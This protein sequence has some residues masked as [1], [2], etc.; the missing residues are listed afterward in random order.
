M[1]EF[2]LRGGVCARVRSPRTGQVGDDFLPVFDVSLP[3]SEEMPVWPGDPPVRVARL[4]EPGAIPAVSHLSF[5]SHTGTHVDA[6]AHFL[7]EGATIDRLP[8]DLWLGPAWVAA[9]PGPEPVTAQLLAAAGIPLGTTRL[10][11]CT[12]NSLQASMRTVFDEDFVGLTEDAAGW[13]LASGI[14]LIGIDGP[15]IETYHTLDHPVHHRLLGAGVV[16]VEGLA[17]AEIVPGPYQLCC[18][19]LRIRGGDGAP[20]RALLLS[21]P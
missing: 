5:G 12:D 8:L 16:I 17:L 1:V 14:R 18:L 6:P 10:L 2:W 4:G 9:L 3:V 21:E 13:L 11:L 7:P 19:P 20:A 15:S